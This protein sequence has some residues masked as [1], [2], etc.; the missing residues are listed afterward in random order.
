MMMTMTM[1]A[2]R[3]TDQ[4]ELNHIADSTAA[5]SVSVHSEVIAWIEILLGGRREG[6]KVILSRLLDWHDETIRGCRNKSQSFIF[7]SHIL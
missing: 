7:F 4:V 6:A 3:L 5:M 1:M 2:W